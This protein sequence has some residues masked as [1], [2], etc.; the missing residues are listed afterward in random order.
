MK[1]A[2]IVAFSSILG[3]YTALGVLYNANDAP[4]TGWWVASPGSCI[5]F[6]VA[7]YLPYNED[8]L[9]ASSV[10]ANAL[11]YGAIASVLFRA[12][13]KRLRRKLSSTQA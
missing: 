9:W 5:V 6:F 3:G 11:L 1:H 12:I 8:A 2:L 10:I 7:Q 13:Q 4:A